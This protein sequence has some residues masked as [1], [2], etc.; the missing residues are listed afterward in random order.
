MEGAEPGKVTFY[1]TGVVEI[2]IPAKA[3]I[4]GGVF[5][6]W[7]SWTSACAGVTMVVLGS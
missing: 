6:G 2:V 5:C 3:G 4:Q 7:L 1:E